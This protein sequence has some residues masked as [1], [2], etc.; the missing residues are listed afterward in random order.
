MAWVQNEL[1]TSYFVGK[2]KGFSVYHLCGKP[3]LTC[4]EYL[5]VLCN[6]AFLLS[7]TIALMQTSLLKLL[8]A[9]F[10]PFPGLDAQDFLP[11]SF[12]SV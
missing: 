10:P 3:L 8:T 4:F 12:S 1:M 9:C 6:V 5:K 7:F 2:I 11:S